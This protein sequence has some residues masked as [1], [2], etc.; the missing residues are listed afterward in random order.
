[1]NKNFWQFITKKARKNGT[2]SD[3]QVSINTYIGWDEY[4]KDKATKAPEFLRKIKAFKAIGVTEVEELA[5]WLYM[6]RRKNRLDWERIDKN[7]KKIKANK[8][9]YSF[10]PGLTLPPRWVL[11]E[12]EHTMMKCVEHGRETPVF[13]YWDPATLDFYER[14]FRETKKHFVDKLSYIICGGNSDF[15]ECGY[16]AG[17]MDPAGEYWLIGRCHAHPGFWCNDKF[18]RDDFKRYV[19]SKYHTIYKVNRAWRTNFSAI[20][21]ITYPRDQERK[22]YWLDFVDWYY[23]SAIN[24]AKKEL[25]MI[26]NI[27][28]ETPIKFKP[29]GLYNPPTTLGLDATGFAKLAAR[30]KNMLTQPASMFG[31]AFWSKWFGS[32]Y[33]FYGVPIGT[34]EGGDT[35]YTSDRVNRIFTDL[36]YG[37]KCL[38]F[39]KKTLLTDYAVIDKYSRYFTGEMPIP[40]TTVIL[41]PSTE[42]KV[43]KFH[44]YEMPEIRSAIMGNK[45]RDV[46]DYD[47]FD[48]RCIHDGALDGHQVLLILEGNTLESNTF[49]K[50]IEWV[51]RGGVLISY[52]FGTI[53]TVEGS[54]KYYRELFGFIKPPSIPAEEVI[55]GKQVSLNKILKRWTKRVGRG[56]TVFFPLTWNERKYFYE[57]VRT[58]IYNLSHLDSHLKNEM[59]VENE[60][61]GVEA[62]L[63]PTKILFLNR[64]T[65]EVK[66][67]V[68]LRGKDFSHWPKKQRPTRYYY[69]LKLPPNSIG[70]IYVA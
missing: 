68:R 39:F 4:T 7:F 18:A 20:K 45:L 58:L 56:Y 65:A 10:M 62:T 22:R 15:G 38:F 8:L 55:E 19:K 50:I 3:S 32:A 24:F 11:D 9:L 16:P 1:M 36:S 33:R 28:P 35:P 49:R 27:F 53:A 63:F 37:V 17:C 30:Y 54:R 43:D 5:S 6:E 29:G 51:R 70:C 60:W 13:S 41:L 46:I 23:Q 21:S 34:E 44:I 52:N 2:I 31:N 67:E 42:I 14:A 57:L 48:E 61:D 25:D 47:V 66:K 40:P 64:G 59:L 26:K 12:K 69:R